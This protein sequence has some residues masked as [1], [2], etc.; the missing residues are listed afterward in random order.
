[1]E[2]NHTVVEV[3]D[4]SMRQVK[5]APVRAV[6]RAIDILSGFSAE[7][8]EMSIEEITANT[9]LPKA[10]VYRMLYTLETKELVQYNA[11]TARYRLGLKLIEYA[12]IV[13]A[14][15]SVT[16]ESEEILVDLHS[17]LHQ[18]VLMAVLEGDD[19]IYVFRRENFEGLK[20]SSFVGQRRKP[21]YGIV[22]LVMLAFLPSLQVD[23]LLAEPLP[24][25]TPNTETDPKAIRRRLETIRDQGYG[26]DIEETT[27]GVSGV[28]APVFGS[29]GEL[30]ATVGVIGPV[31]QLIGP[32]LQEAA[33]AV[34]EATRLISQRVGYQP[35]K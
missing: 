24:K 2:A 13:H 15:H 17:R 23:K 1:M 33:Q 19:M 34:Q 25:N 8:P 31:V 26:I 29:R 4:K 21:P 10:T 18:T 9:D 7:R 14:T 20:F 32:A 6:E 3:E 5:I 11:S 22:G 27:L 30:L 16:H 28:A 12:G 35:R